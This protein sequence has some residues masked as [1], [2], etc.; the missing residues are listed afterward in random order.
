MKSR[1]WV[2]IRNEGEENIVTPDDNEGLTKAEATGR[3]L[4]LIEIFKIPK[5]NVVLIAVY[6]EECLTSN[7]KTEKN[8]ILQ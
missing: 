7:Q 1:F 2:G 6:E 8:I 3:R 4:K 5:E